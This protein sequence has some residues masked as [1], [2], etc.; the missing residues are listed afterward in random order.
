[1]SQWISVK[2]EYPTS[3]MDG[4]AL[5][6]AVKNH[7]DEIISETDAWHKYSKEPNGGVFHFWGNKVTHWMKLPEPPK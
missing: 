4:I 2:D 3:D 5:I 7:A 1:M 6:V